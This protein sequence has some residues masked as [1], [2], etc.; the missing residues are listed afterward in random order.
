MTSN[1]TENSS[2]KMST[3][4]LLKPT[5]FPCLYR[6]E[7][8]GRY[9]ARKKNKGKLKQEVLRAENGNAIVD[10]KLAERA[11]R[12]WLEN[13]DNPEVQK[14]N[15]QMTFAELLEKHRAVTAGLA[16]KSRNNV[17][18]MIGRLKKSWQGGLDVNVADIKTSDAGAWLA[19]QTDLKPASFNEISRQLKNI[20]ELAVHDEV[21]AKS[22]LAGLLKK[23]KRKRIQKAPDVIP[24]EAEFNK[25]ITTI[26][27]QRFADH[28]QDSAD[29]ATFLGL[30]ALGEAE[31][32]RLTWK[33]VDFET[34][35]LA[36]RRKKTGVYFDVRMCDDLKAF[37]LALYEKNKRPVS[38][39][40]VFKVDCCKRTL[41]TVCKKLHLPHFTPRSL[42][43]F[44]VTSLLRQGI[45]F[46]LVSA[47]QG[48]Q[49]GGKLI[50]D[51]YSHII[52]SA[53]AEFEKAELA[54]MKTRI[55]P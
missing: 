53:D 19:M 16:D 11:L 36:I 22:P 51:T 45:S 27:K 38:Y 17:E 21:I 34:G 3:N 55:T 43:K 44:G 42:R 31:A 6:H 14:T 5:G 1:Q 15:A 25:I 2:V 26:R 20:F 37:L 12:I 41:E 30:A 33:D 39:E 40:R 32:K 54:K 29:L 28:A 46:K 35:K 9:Y 48:H 47:W 4:H 52:S 24:S 50:L 8:T 18:W 7:K 10:R 49:D 13:L 23:Q